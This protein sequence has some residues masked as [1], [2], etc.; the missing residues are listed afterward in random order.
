MSSVTRV[1]E[2]FSGRIAGVGSASGVRIVVG[3]W[4]DSP[5]G[6][7]ADVMVEDAAGHRVLLAPSERVRTPRSTTRAT[8][9][10]TEHQA[11]D[12][13]RRLGTAVSRAPSGVRPPVTSRSESDGVDTCQPSAVSSTV[14]GS[15]TCSSNE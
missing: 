5:W 6:A 1:R 15:M 4:D 3:R 8:G 12:V 13:A 10:T 11:G 14:T 9:S 2:R 7:F